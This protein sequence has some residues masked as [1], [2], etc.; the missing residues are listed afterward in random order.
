VTLL[1]QEIKAFIG[2]ESDTEVACDT[3]ELGAV[4]RYAQAIMDGDVH[5]QSEEATRESRY[6]RPVAPPLFPIYT[7]RR[8]F[9]TPDPFQER[10]QDPDFD[11]IVGSTAQGLPPLPLEGFSLLNAGTE[12]ELIRYAHHGEAVTAKSSYDDIFEKEGRSGPML[13]VVIKTEYRTGDGS[14]LMRVR[15]TQIRKK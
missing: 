5:Y 6:G 13:F 15:K 2:V 14:L 9:G 10:G 3:V 7:F 4:R 12:I 1:T 11:G 8:P